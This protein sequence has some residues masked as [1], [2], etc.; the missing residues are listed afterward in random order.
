MKHKNSISQTYIKRDK[1]AIPKLFRRA[2]EIAEYPTT[3]KRLFEIVADL[4]TQQFY[5]A[6]DAAMSYIRKRVMHG[7]HKKFRNPYKQR[8]FDA[9]YE[10]VISMLKEEKYKAMGLKNT[11]ICALSR[12]APCIGLTPFVIFRL[13][14]RNRKTNEQNFQT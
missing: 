9:L 10:E 14:V 13:Y 1:E 7:E 5:V 11:V 2:K 3:T 4:P 6:D 12:P 8:L